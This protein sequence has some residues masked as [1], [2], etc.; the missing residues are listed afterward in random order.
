MIIILV[1]YIIIVSNSCDDRKPWKQKQ[2]CD[3]RKRENNVRQRRVGQNKKIYTA[4]DNISTG[5][6]HT[7]GNV[8]EYIF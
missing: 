7:L 8:N 5:N 6:T 4:G 2:F 1:Y 3:F